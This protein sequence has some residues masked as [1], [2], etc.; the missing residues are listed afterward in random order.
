MNAETM[1]I[2]QRYGAIRQLAFVPRDFD[3]AIEFWTKTMG[4]G[5]FFYLE[6]IPL[7]DVIYKGKQIEYDCSA[8]IAY[9]GDMEIEILRQ[10]NPGP[11]IL[12]DWI[13]KGREGVHHVRLTVDDLETARQEF[14]GLGGTVIQSARLPGGGEYIMMDMPGPAPT[15]EL[16]VLHPRFIRL[17]EYM[18]RASQQWDGSDPLRPVPPEDQWAS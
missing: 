4:V 6:H 11:S 14:E 10:H 13:E 2:P 1:L 7:E 16:S 15:I 8:A 3:A 9:W 5:P 18:K 12:T 17:W